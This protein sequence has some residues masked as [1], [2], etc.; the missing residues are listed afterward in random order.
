MQLPFPVLVKVNV[1]EPLA[2]SVVLGVYTA[3]SALMLGENPPV[4]P[5]QI[6]PVALLIEPANCTLELFAQTVRSRPASTTGAGAMVITTWSFTALQVPL[7]VDV[8]VN[9]T[10]PAAISPKVGV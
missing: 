7:F 10:V 5:L 2:S 4:P 6:P 1:I 8:S 3:F 9:V